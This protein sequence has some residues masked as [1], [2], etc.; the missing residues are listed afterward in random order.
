MIDFVHHI[1]LE[2]DRFRSAA[3][4]LA[5]SGGAAGLAAAPVPTCPDWTA[6]DLVWH[7]AEVQ[8]FW[9]SIVEANLA[10]P[11]EVGELV[12]PADDGLLALFDDCSTR[13]VS[14]V[15]D[16]DGD[17]PCWSWHD[18]GHSVGWVR[19]RQAHEALIHRIDAELTVGDGRL[20]ATRP[21]DT[22]LAADGVDEMVGVM[23]EVGS[24]PDWARF[25][26]DGRTIRLD[27]PGRSWTLALGRFV[28]TDPSGTAH[29]LPA[30]TGL[31]AVDRPTA[32][33]SGPAAELD[34][35]LWRRAPLAEAAID[36]DPAVVEWLHEA[37]AVR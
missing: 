37:G 22:Q 18:D 33:V 28:G 31:P 14:A 26:R 15:R 24:V 1:E 16:H 7:L 21:I 13:L 25:D 9:A 17:E 27:V 19:R 35:W 3:G 29:D 2:S 5:S 36:G 8:H 4:A 30:V 11:S 32:I 23:L 12:R 20:E 34:L 6:A 10:D